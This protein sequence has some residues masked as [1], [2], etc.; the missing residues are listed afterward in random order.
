MWTTYPHNSKWINACN[1][2]FFLVSNT[3]I[4]CLLCHQV[5][6]LKLHYLHYLSLTSIASSLSS[7]QI[8][9]LASEIFYSSKHNF[10]AQ[11]Q[12]D[13]KI[14]VTKNESP[15]EKIILIQ[16]LENERL[17]TQHC[18]RDM[19]AVNREGNEPI[20]QPKTGKCQGK[21]TD[22]QTCPSKDKMK[23]E[24]FCCYFVTVEET[25]EA[26]QRQ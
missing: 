5:R 22:Q 8:C 19:W 6:H 10:T 15:K 4:Q 21:G 23:E 20:I 9:T 16:W 17:R 3:K 14:L 24:F 18:Q 25:K 1:F 11:N 13:K 26:G 7:W 2:F 12:K